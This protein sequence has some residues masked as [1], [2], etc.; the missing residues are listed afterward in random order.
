[1]IIAETPN[2]S[3]V[4]TVKVKCSGFPPVSPSYIILVVTSRISFIVANLEVKSTAS[5]SGFPQ[6]RIS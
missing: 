2:L 3:R 6:S 4:L 5:M 1:M